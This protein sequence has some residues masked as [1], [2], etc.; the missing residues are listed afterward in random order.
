MSYINLATIFL[1]FSACQAN[2]ENVTS[3]LTTSNDIVAQTP[4]P[5][6]HSPGT[7][8]LERFNPPP[9]YDRQHCLTGSF[10]EYLRNLPLKPNE[11]P[12][13]F[14][15]GS[16]K[17]SNKHAAVLDMDIGDRDLQQCADAIMRIRAEYFFKRKEYDQISYHFVNGFSADYNRWAKGERIS[18][19]GNTTKWYGN[20]SA[21]Y[22]YQNFRDYL[23]MV[24]IYAGTASLEKELKP[25]PIADLSI[26]DVFIR[27]G[28]PGHAMLIVDVALNE[29]GKKVFMLAQ[30]YMPAQSIH[31]VKN[32]ENE[33][34]SPWYELNES[35][36]ILDTPSWNF[37]YA[38]L[39]SF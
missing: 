30:S 16:L 26:G 25:K 10:G 32:L 24:Y 12:V 23:T 28:S 19:K 15:D 33:K 20:K 38:E 36:M 29:T 34:I 37:Y 21:D 2:S 13:L 8:I 27:G 7:T 18:V 4:A 9:G 22:S 31:I 1:I 39:R 14:Y 35:E 3:I 6:S 11:S 17:N 5:I